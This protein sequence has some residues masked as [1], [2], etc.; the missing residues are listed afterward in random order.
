MVMAATT[1]PWTR[2]ELERLPDDGNRYEVLD[3]V[4][5]VTPAPGAP[6]Q[7][8]AYN[9]GAALYAYCK[10]HRIGHGAAPAALREG[11]SE[12]QP[13]IAVY[14][15]AGLPF[16]ASWDEYPT[17]GL[18]VEILSPSTRRRDI[19]IKRA[20]YLRWA[21]PEYWMVDVERRAITVVRPGRADETV[22]DTLR[23][24]PLSDVP[25]LVLEI[26]ALFR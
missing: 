6:H 26:S 24:Q 3:G 10:Q 8:F 15:D 5:L 21:V 2:A 11:D 14:F 17:P 13:D 19:G 16:N 20:A 23:W 4:L 7:R 25:A 9:L 12:L 22:T 1:R 18:V